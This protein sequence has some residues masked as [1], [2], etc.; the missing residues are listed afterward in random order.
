MRIIGPAL[1]LLG[2][3]LVRS[4]VGAAEPDY[5][6]HQSIALSKAKNGFDGALL[7]VEDARIT[8]ALRERMWDVDSDPLRFLAPDSSLWAG[9]KAKAPLWA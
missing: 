4:E 7:L 2:L 6:V 3:L 9:F 8:P 1:L 5:L